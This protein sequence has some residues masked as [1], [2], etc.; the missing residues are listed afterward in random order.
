MLNS[1]WVFS[2]EPILRHN[3]DSNEQET[4]AD[5]D[6]YIERDCVKYDAETSLAVLIRWSLIY[7]NK[8]VEVPIVA[9]SIAQERL[10]DLLQRSGDLVVYLEGGRAHRLK[11][12]D[13]AVIKV[14]LRVYVV[15]VDI[16]AHVCLLRDWVGVVAVDHLVSPVVNVEARLSP[17]GR[18]HVRGAGAHRRAH[19]LRGPRARLRIEGLE[20]VSQVRDIREGRLQVACTYIAHHSRQV[21][22]YEQEESCYRAEDHGDHEGPETVLTE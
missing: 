5:D 8:E 15:L 2:T 1:I 14:G 7:V 22:T 20:V 11:H 13:V 6:S 12:V 16:E 9:D 4:C 21:D 18:L 19:V 3:S 10:L 17:L